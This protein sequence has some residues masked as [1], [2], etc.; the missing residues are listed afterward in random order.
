MS[1]SASGKPVS[2]LVR[3]A[4]ANKSRTTVFKKFRYGPRHPR[5]GP[6]LFGNLENVAEIG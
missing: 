5:L 2:P 4:F 1:K 3:Q 6:S